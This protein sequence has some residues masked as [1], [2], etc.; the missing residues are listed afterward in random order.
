MLK[1]SI[2]S[3]TY[4]CVEQL[5]KHLASV[6]N[7]IFRNLEHI[8]I[9][10]LSN[11]GTEQVVLDYQK[12]ADYPVIYVRE[13]DCGIYQANNK[14]IKRASGQWIHIL[15]ADNAYPSENTL[16][17][18]FS[19]DWSGCDLIAGGVVL[20]RKT[21]GEERPVYLR[22]EYEPKLKDFRFPHQG[23]LIRRSFYQ[24]YGCYSEKFRVVS[25]SI[26]AI[27]NYPKARWRIIDQPVAILCDGGISGTMSLTNTLE[28]VMVFLF[29]H[30][31]PLR[32]R[33]RPAASQIYQY[34][35]FVISRR[36][37]G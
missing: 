26:F 5:R 29:F 3:P 23:T 4:N 14:G 33:L 17:E 35:K 27:R 8:I 34:V 2:I 18:V 24:K 19:H 10:N 9:D 15:N 13:R 31:Y 11:D 6:Q 25:D 20:N 21:G 37:I 30:Q 1:L 12:R 28:N 22:P 36:T 7:Q 16:Q 32:R